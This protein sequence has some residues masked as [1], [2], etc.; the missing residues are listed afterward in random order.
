MDDALRIILRANGKR[1]TTQRISVLRYLCESG[2]PMTHG[3][4]LSALPDLDRVT[5]Y[6]ILS[7]FVETNIAHQVQGSDGAWRFCAHI[8]GDG[9]EAGCPGGHAHFLCVECGRMECLI[10]Q[11]MPKVD[12][13]EGTVV[14]GKQLVVFGLCAD[15][16]SKNTAGR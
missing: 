12:V 7:A 2:R 3:E 16:A 8:S 14:H 1:A 9:D 13:P 15:H 6:R 5:L 10:D 4:I 11:K